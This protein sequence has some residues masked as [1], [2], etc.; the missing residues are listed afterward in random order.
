[1]LGSGAL[2][3]L[4]GSERCGQSGPWTTNVCAQPA[5]AGNFV[6]CIAPTPLRISVQISNVTSVASRTRTA[7]SSA[8]A[9]TI[10]AN[11]GTTG[12]LRVHGFPFG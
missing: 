10:W 2:N 11:S 8:G 12:T 9:A 7:R 4:L 3:V 1:M 6:H 5:S